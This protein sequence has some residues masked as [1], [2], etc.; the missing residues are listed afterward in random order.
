MSMKHSYD[1]YAH[2]HNFFFLSVCH[3]TSFV[4]FVISDWF[5]EST[6]F[7][8]HTE[9]YD[10]LQHY[11]I[12]NNMLLRTLVVDGIITRFYHLVW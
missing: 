12:W 4:D 10:P 9:A 1:L 2:L 5:L 6:Y 3:N 11:I 7:D 8:R